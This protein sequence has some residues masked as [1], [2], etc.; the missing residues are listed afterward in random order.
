MQEK[1]HRQDAKAAKEGKASPPRTRNRE[2]TQKSQREGRRARAN[3]AG[4]HPHPSPPLEGEG[5]EE[6]RLPFQV[7]LPPATPSRESS[8]PPLLPG[9]APSQKTPSLPGGFAPK[10][11]LPPQGEGWDGGGGRTLLSLSEIGD[12]HH[13]PKKPHREERE[14]REEGNSLTAKNAK[15][16]KKSLSKIYT[17]ADTSSEDA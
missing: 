4:T 12:P 13:F 8:L 5:R 6:K 10:K 9:K 7:K 11:L 2:G 16:A 3:S 15:N 14:A 17:R 1:P